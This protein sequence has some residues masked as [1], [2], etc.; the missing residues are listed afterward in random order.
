[1]FFLRNFPLLEVTVCMV[2]ACNV[3]S[4]IERIGDPR[5]IPP[6]TP[7]SLQGKGA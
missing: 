5:R 7:K 6:P 3:Q 1:M 2:T 4:K